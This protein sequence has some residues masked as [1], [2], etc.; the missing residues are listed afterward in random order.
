V[1]IADDREPIT[2]RDPIH[3]ENS[4]GGEELRIGLH[5]DRSCALHRGIENRI[6][7]RPVHGAL[8]RRPA[9]LQ[10]DHRL[11]PRRGAQRRKESPR[12]ADRLRVQQDAFGFGIVEQC[13]EQL[14]ETDV[15][16]AA[17]RD[18]GRKSDAG[19]CREIE[20]AVHTAPDCATSA[21][22][23]RAMFVRVALRP[24]FVRITPNECGPTIRMRRVAAMARSS[25]R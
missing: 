19:R 3:R 23:R 4:R 16:A 21:S 11:G 24:M 22:T 7:R 18:D 10:Q 6:G 17:K 8:L 14:A 12:V 25:R 15:D 20:H 13:I 5:A 2:A 1:P 9:G